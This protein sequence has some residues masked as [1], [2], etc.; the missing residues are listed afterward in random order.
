[1]KAF[2]ELPLCIATL[3]KTGASQFAVLSVNVAFEATVGPLFK[4]QASNFLELIP[5]QEHK[6]KLMEAVT[7]AHGPTKT[8]K[9][10][11]RGSRVRNIE[12]ITVSESNS[13][14]PIK[15]HFDWT[16]SVRDG[17]LNQGTT[18]LL[19]GDP[20]SEQDSEQRAKDAELVDF[21]Q[22]APIALHWLSGE[23]IV[24]WA[25]KTEMDVLGYTPEEY[26]GQPI[27]K[28]CPDEEALVLEIFK[29]LGSGNTIRDVPVRFRTKAGK[30]VHFLIDSNV[31][32]DANGQFA[33]TR[34]FIRDDTKRKI[35]DAQA[36]LLHEETKRSLKMLDNFM[37]RSMHHVRTPMH[38]LQTTV[39][40][41]SHN[42][43]H[44]QK[45][46]IVANDESLRLLANESLEVLQQARNCVSQ[47]VDLINDISDLARLD[48]GHELKLNREP[49]ELK[50]LGK[51]AFANIPIPSHIEA[52]IEL[53]GGGPRYLQ[54]DGNLLHKVIRSAL[55]H[56]THSPDEV[57]NVKTVSLVIGHN[58]E[59]NKC[60]FAIIGSDRRMSSFDLLTHCMSHS[61]DERGLPS[62]F[63]RYTQR[64][65][66]G[67][68]DDTVRPYD[69]ASTTRQSV[70]DAINSHRVSSLHIGLPLSHHLVRALGG[71][72]RYSNRPG[73]TTFRWAL[74][75]KDE[76]L[77]TERIIISSAKAEPQR[78]S[79]FVLSRD[80]AKPAALPEAVASCGLD[81]MDSPCVL[82]VDDV[83][84]CLKMVCNILGKLNCTHE[85]AENGQK[86]VD[87]LKSGAGKYDL[88]LMD[89]RMPVMDGLTATKIIKKDLKLGVP[90]VALT[91]DA[92]LDIKEQCDAIGFDEFCNKPM[93][94]NAIKK[95]VDRL[96]FKKKNG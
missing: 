83:P 36:Q 78:A 8:T 6:D 44:V 57:E 55:D 7:K 22:N 27:M 37:S 25:N 3:R 59:S 63:Q 77:E 76:S 62:I 2:D 9:P 10:G 91:G 51:T 29:Q 60:V 13:G 28:F 47:S 41:V 72:L 34:C 56:I 74:P 52:S 32:Y 15:R 31:K 71:D 50:E 86:A 12:M 38:I 73:L 90:V 45:R 92:G 40:I 93:K 82:V 1:M 14:L 39:D 79:S 26:I 84:M 54:T 68:E 17:T 21:F 61:D 89:L 70:E 30:I 48:Q 16:I 43:I 67:A 85:T 42:L 53:L 24:L 80:E 95:L 65:T 49:V 11:S 81:A 96:V 23:G 19:M 66:P 5:Q 33:H 20:V 69:V 75:Y 64:F 46:A 58:E 35:R 4:I 88:V 87:L 94:K 18:F